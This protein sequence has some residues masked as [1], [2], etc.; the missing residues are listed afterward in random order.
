VKARTDFLD[1]MASSIFICC[2]PTGLSLMH[3]TAAMPPKIT[4]AMA[5]KHKC[6]ITWM[7][8]LL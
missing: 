3:E 5:V 6:Q 4:P 1:V 8:G 2:S 7:S